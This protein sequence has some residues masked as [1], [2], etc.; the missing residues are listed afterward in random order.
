MLMGKFDP[1]TIGGEPRPVNEPT[2]CSTALRARMSVR[3]QNITYLKQ[4]EEIKFNPVKILKIA[5]DTISSEQVREAFVAG[6]TSD[7]LVQSRRDIVR[8]IVHVLKLAKQTQDCLV[9]SHT[10]RLTV[11]R[12]YLMEGERLSQSPDLIRKY[13]RPQSKLMDFEQEF[14][15]RY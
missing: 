9:I 15:E 13:I 4:L 12:A 8:E 6:W 5:S 14:V 7:S 11:I 10:F 2:L 1:P 3:G